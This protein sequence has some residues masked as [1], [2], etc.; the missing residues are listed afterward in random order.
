MKLMPSHSSS[1]V[2]PPGSMR[3]PH[4]TA[5]VVAA[6]AL[7]AAAH[8]RHFAGHAEWDGKWPDPPSLSDLG[9]VATTRDEDYVAAASPRRR[10]PRQ[11]PVVVHAGILLAWSWTLPRD[12]PTKAYAWISVPPGVR[13]PNRPQRTRNG[14]AGKALSLRAAA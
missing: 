5:L 14:Y 12:S 9:T 11:P 8:E 10:L 3:H 2:P 4:L 13:V 7:L 6:I 1:P